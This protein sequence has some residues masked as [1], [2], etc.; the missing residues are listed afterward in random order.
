[1]ISVSCE[2]FIDF[3]YLKG[4]AHVHCKAKQKMGHSL[5]ASSLGI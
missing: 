5:S 2:E 4:K 1:V 3:V